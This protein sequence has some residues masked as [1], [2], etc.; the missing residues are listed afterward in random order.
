MD[1]SQDRLRIESNG[2]L[3]FNIMVPYIKPSMVSSHEI[4]G[5]VYRVMYR[6]E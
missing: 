3:K 5:S 1:L 6:K 4:Q 2:D